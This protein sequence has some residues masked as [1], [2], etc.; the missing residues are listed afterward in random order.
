MKT[1]LILLAMSLPATMFSQCHFVTHSFL[2]ISQ[3]G[4][5]EYCHSP[6]PLT[7]DYY[8]NEVRITKGDEILY[9]GDLEEIIDEFPI[10][11]LIFKEWVV[12]VT[13]VNMCDWIGVAK[14]DDIVI[15]VNNENRDYNEIVKKF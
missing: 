13:N 1:L 4:E 6:E 11:K 3:S 15:F 12:M 10:Q 14:G 7:L 9:I 2:S 8:F 5:W